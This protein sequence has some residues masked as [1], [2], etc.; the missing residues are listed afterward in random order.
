M[1]AGSAIGGVPYG[2]ARLRGLEAGVAAQLLCG[3]LMG[4]RC[5]CGFDLPDQLRGGR[6]SIGLGLWGGGP[7]PGVPRPGRPA[8]RDH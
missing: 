1:V 6:C 7:W 5:S 3:P 4:D 2:P 8:R